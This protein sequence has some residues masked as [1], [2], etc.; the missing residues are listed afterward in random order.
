MRVRARALRCV[1][2]ALH[3]PRALAAPAA[4]PQGDAKA[5]ANAIY[6]KWVLAKYEAFKAALREALLAADKP[7]DFQ[8]LAMVVLLQLTQSASKLNEG[9]GGAA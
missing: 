2:R 1:P 8:L 3:R 9:A 5:K 4:C 6:R 7:Q